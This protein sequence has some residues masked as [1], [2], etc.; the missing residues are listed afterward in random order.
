[1]ALAARQVRKGLLFVLLAFIVLFTAEQLLLKLLDWRAKW[2][3]DEFKA[4]LAN[5]GPRNEDSSQI[6]GCQYRS[7]AWFYRYRI[8]IKDLDSQRTSSQNVEEPTYTLHIIGAAGYLSPIPEEGGD[9]ETWDSTNIW[10]VDD[11]LRI[12]D[13]MR[14]G[15][16]G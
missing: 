11:E 15:A 14:K 7:I 13:D 9:R 1:M 10:V 4:Y 12:V 2:R 6:Y 5:P 8:C 3:D 16:G